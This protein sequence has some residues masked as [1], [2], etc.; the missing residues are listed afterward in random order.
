MLKLD[1]YFTF[2]EIPWSDVRFHIYGQL[3]KMVSSEDVTPIELFY[4]RRE[5]EN[6]SMFFVIRQKDYEWLWNS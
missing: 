2:N 1:M 4:S 6:S 5:N 3:L